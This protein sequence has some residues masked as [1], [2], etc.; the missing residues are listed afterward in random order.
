MLWSF[1]LL[2]IIFFVYNTAQYIVIYHWHMNQTYEEIRKDMNSIQDYFI[3]EKSDQEQIADATLFVEKIVKNNQLIRVINNNGDPVLIVSNDLPEQGVTPKPVAKPEMETKWYLEDH[4]L[5]IRSPLI[6]GNFTG[7]VEII[8]NLESLDN[9]NQTL[10]V[11]MLSGAGIAVILSGLGGLLISRQLLKPIQSITE[12]MKKIM[13]NGLQE[14]V[15]FHDNKDELSYLAIMFNE[16]MEQ[17]EKSFRQQKQFVEDASHELRT[18]ISII[19]GHLSLLNRWGK[20]NTDILDESL[21]SSLEEIVRLKEL[22]QELLE[23]SRAEAIHEN[24]IED[25]ADARSIIQQ[26]VND[27]SVLHS[28]VEFI[29]RLAKEECL[30]QIS[31]HH[32]KQIILIILDNAVKYSLNQKMIEINMDLVQSNTASIQIMD[33]GVGIPKEDI[34]FVF[35][36]FYRVDKARNRKLGG[37]GLGLAIAKRIINKYHGDILIESNENEGTSV[38]IWLPCRDEYID[39]GS[40][41]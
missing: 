19:E 28:D 33:H 9:L 4:L 23:L 39:R 32:L 2:F 40:K 17:L 3:A 36:R 5:I 20:T 13:E 6:T 34:P 10:I 7:T 29:V 21:T 15:P 30:L 12:T 27:L 35:D 18:P 26:V 25:W 38:T 8:N 24:A 1:I 11:I 41:S 14:R 31:T 16:M 37:S 22:V